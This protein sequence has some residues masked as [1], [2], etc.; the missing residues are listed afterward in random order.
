M[1]MWWGRGGLNVKVCRSSKRDAPVGGIACEGGGAHGNIT[2]A[3]LH[4]KAE[5]IQ[6]PVSN[7]G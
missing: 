7:L 2:I 1:N 5:P 4:L 6:P 3:M